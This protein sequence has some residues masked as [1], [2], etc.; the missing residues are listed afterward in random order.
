MNPK[1][2]NEPS[3]NVPEIKPEAPGNTQY[4]QSSSTSALISETRQLKTFDITPNIRLQLDERR[5]KGVE[6]IM[7]YERKKAMWQR[8]EQ[9][10]PDG[11]KQCNVA[12]IIRFITYRIGQVRVQYGLDAYQAESKTLGMEDE[13]TRW[14]QIILKAREEANAEI[15]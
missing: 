9:R 10:N 3:G 2:P 6:L 11:G 15:R 12:G 7:Y 4:S 5:N 1:T 13:E 8:F 14:K